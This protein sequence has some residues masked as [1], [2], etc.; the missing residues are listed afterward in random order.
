MSAN[1]TQHG[2]DHYKGKAIQPWD[3]IEANNIPFLEGSAIKYL[4][5]WRDKGGVE[6]LRKALHFIQKRIELEEAKVK[7]SPDH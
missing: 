6:D 2:G 4:T 1:D 5:R 7:A 3:Y